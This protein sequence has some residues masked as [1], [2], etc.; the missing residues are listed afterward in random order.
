[1]FVEGE[2]PSEPRGVELGRDEARPERFGKAKFHLGLV[3]A[4]LP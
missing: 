1:M 4:T 2:A 3:A